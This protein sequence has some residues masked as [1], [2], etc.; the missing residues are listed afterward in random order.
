MIFIHYPNSVNHFAV[1]EHIKFEQINF[2]C[3][4]YT[5]DFFRTSSVAHFDHHLFFVCVEL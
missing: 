2:V 4:L 3:T 1:F 5:I